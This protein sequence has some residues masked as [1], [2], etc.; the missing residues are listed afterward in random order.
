MIDPLWATLWLVALLVIAVLE[1][2]ALVLKQTTL[3]RTI[4][5]F[6]DTTLKR[7]VGIAFF[8]VL[9][10]HFFVPPFLPGWTVL[11]TAVPFG[12][13][14]IRGWLSH[15]KEEALKAVLKYSVRK[16]AAKS[17]QAVGEAVLG[18]VAAGGIAALVAGVDAIL[19]MIDEAGELQNLGVPVVVSGAGVF[20]ARFLANLWKVKR[21][22]LVSR[23]G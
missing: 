2:V 15:R 9:L 21:A 6:Y 11:V 18:I 10:L 22:E 1:V 20:L 13:I 7:I 3:T 4:Q 14:F 17:G 12:Y 5:A 23:G 8:T 16:G 19:P